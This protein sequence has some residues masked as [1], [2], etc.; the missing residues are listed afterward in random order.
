MQTLLAKSLLP[1]DKVATAPSVCL[2]GPTVS[3]SLSF[4]KTGILA[5]HCH[6]IPAASRV[7][8]SLLAQSMYSLGDYRAWRG[9][10]VWER[11]C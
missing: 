6:I 9:K 10:C 1:V 4:Q 5:A 8:T 3:S 11:L 2:P 7:T